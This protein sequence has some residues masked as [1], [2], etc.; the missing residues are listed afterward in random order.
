[1]ALAQFGAL[2]A[3]LEAVS[4][5]VAA[6]MLLGGFVVGVAGLLLA[7]SRRDFEARVLRYGYLGGIAAVGTVLADITFRYAV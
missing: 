2:T 7:W 4:A 1:M 5:A 6:G 3:L